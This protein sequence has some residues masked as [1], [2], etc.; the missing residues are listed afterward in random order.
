MTSRG[1]VQA[2]HAWAPETDA[3]VP[4][5]E[6]SHGTVVTVPEKQVAALYS[7]CINEDM[8]TLAGVNI[9]STASYLLGDFP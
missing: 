9:F 1:D 2:W 4:P 7:I 3:P 6:P 5:R 8:Y